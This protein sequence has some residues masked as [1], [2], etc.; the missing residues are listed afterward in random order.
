MYHEI[1]KLDSIIIISKFRMKRI[2]VHGLRL[3][4]K[5][6][7]TTIQGQLIQPTIEEYEN[8]LIDQEVID[9]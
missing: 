3:E 6:F 5:S 8:F 4:F 9:K 2:I 1:S 7:V